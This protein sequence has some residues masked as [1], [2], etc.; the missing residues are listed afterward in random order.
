M[1]SPMPQSAPEPEFEFASEADVRPQGVAQE[2]WRVLLVDDDPDVHQATVFAVGAHRFVGRPVEFLHAYNADQARE[3]LLVEKGLAFIL[4][5]VVMES[6]SAGLELVDFIRQTAGLAH[7]RIVLRTGQPG[8]APELETILRYDI[9][10]YKSKAEL[11]QLKL[12]TLFT[13]TL[14]SYQQ[15]RSI[16]ANK[17]ALSQIVKASSS[18]M[19]MRGMDDFAIGVI[20]Q[21][22]DLLGGYH[23]GLVC[24]TVHP[25][26][27][28]PRVLVASGRFSAHIHAALEQ[29]PEYAVRKRLTQAFG[30]GQSAFGKDYMALYFG[31]KDGLDMA[32]YVDTSSLVD[33]LDS[34]LLKVFCAQLSACLRNQSLIA[35]LRAQAFVDELLQ[36]P[37][38]ARLIAEID[39]RQ[40]TPHCELAMALV[41]VDDFSAVN[42]LR[43]HHYGDALLKALSQRLQ[44]S[45]GSEVMLARI[46]GNAFALLGPPHSISPEQIHAASDTPL[47]VQGRPH[48]ISLTSGLVG[49]GTG[50]YSGADWLKNATIALKQAKRHARG[51]HVVYTA[52]IGE[53]AR[54]RAQLLADL[55]SAFDKQHLFLMY[56]PQIDLASGA[57]TGLEALMRWRQSDGSLV[58]PD[59]FIPVAEQSGLIVPL[60]AWALQV[61]CEAMQTLMAQDLA[62]LRMAVNVSMEQFKTPDFFDNVLSALQAVDLPGQR[63]ELEITESV[64]MLGS[65]RVQK[66]LGQLRAR[67]IAVSIDDFGTGYSSLS[68]LEQLPL[69]RMKID[70]AFVQ[71]LGGNGSGRIAEMI[72][73]LGQTLGL[74][75]LAEGIEDRASWDTLQAMGCHEGQGFFIARPMELEQLLPWIRNYRARLG[76]APT[77]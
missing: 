75:V 49:L 51:Q 63:L 38:R 55:H 41:D 58:P 24:A 9:N 28:A 15:L 39:Q 26:S 6:D 29:L 42:E 33:P 27:D 60:G 19:H 43:G 14:R 34:E 61:A 48:R 59:R 69:D 18:F 17:Q 3:M 23:D 68:H 1:N 57:L 50:L 53:L 13:T 45:V 74:R 30:Q 12:L 70:K 54:S 4:L 73:E 31:H 10:D 52:D 77:V 44:Q 47:L 11:S 65:K 7:T 8:Y 66:I 62:P 76:L 40:H 56:Q 16:N 25:A 22:A 37:N 71:Q 72:A 21:L 32:A 67:G 46:S 35:Q 2:P 5:D 20:A 64:A 36:L